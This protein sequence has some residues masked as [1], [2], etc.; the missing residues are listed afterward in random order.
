MAEVALTTDDLTVLGGPATVNLEVDF[1]PQGDRGSQIFVG[2]GQPNDPGTVIGQDPE[3]F[4]LYIN[5]LTSDEEYLYYYQ[6][7]NVSGTNTWV[8]LFKLIPNV[9]STNSTGTFVAGERDI[10]IPVINI[11]PSDL[12]G[13]VTASNFNI[14]H[15]IINNTNPLSS[16]LTVGEIVTVDD[17]VTLP[18]S[19]KAIEFDGADW[20][21]LAGEKTVH[22]FI[23]VV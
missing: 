15:N 9:Y 6:Y 11:V 7:Q 23:S 2:N 21:D 16:T 14:Q 22:L 20:I 4:D 12:V 1:G 13:T 3:I 10:N 8:K 5:V 17:I 19:I 18:L